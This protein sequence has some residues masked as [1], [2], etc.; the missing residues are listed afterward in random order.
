MSSKIFTNTKTTTHT[1]A[2]QDQAVVLG[3]GAV[4][5]M[6]DSAG[7]E[8]SFRLGQTAIDRNAATLSEALGVYAEVS[9]MAAGAIQRNAADSL[10][11]VT[12]AYADAGDPAFD[13]ESIVS[14]MVPVFVIGFV[15]LGGIAWAASRK[16]G[17]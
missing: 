11:A 8:A 15:V 16:G 9:E 6:V 17:K 10:S 7:V 5:S 2:A 12:A 3:Q 4:F 13:V 14:K 1:N